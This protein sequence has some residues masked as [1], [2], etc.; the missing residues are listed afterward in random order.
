MTT[1]GMIINQGLS[2]GAADELSVGPPKAGP[3]DAAAR[4]YDPLV[5]P[6]VED[7]AVLPG[8]RATTPQAL[9]EQLEGGLLDA[10]R[11]ALD[12][13]A[14]SYPSLAELFDRWS[15]GDPAGRAPVIGNHHEPGSETWFEVGQRTGWWVSIPMSDLVVL[16]REEELLLKDPSV[17]PGEELGTL[18]R[19]K[20][21][22]QAAAQAIMQGLAEANE[23]L[24]RAFLADATVEQME[25]LHATA[26]HA[27]RLEVHVGSEEANAEAVEADNDR[28]LGAGRPSVAAQMFWLHLRAGDKD[29]SFG[30]ILQMLPFSTE[31][32]AAFSDDDR[33]A[34]QI[35]AT[36]DEMMVRLREVAQSLDLDI[37]DT[38][39][40]LKHDAAAAVSRFQ[41]DN[42]M[43]F[44]RLGMMSGA[45]DWLSE[46]TTLS[47]HLI[48]AALEDPSVLRDRLGPPEVKE[49]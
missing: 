5:N 10:V 29:F 31:K 32:A 37:Y 3:H 4:I 42:A 43:H 30:N 17:P 8:P 33:M 25:V 40:R 27:R 1:I 47:Q 38:D 14:W 41:R 28:A 15:D 16:A 39:A 34:L 48:D 11:D 22:N 45:T 35:A 6:F 9:F 20:T 13:P 24:Q 19:P 18:G 49:P 26:T 7:G 12:G 2:A 46:L 21:A 23:V 44:V 36:T